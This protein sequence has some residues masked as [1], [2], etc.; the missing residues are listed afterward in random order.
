MSGAAGLDFGEDGRA[1]DCLLS[2]CGRI[3][4]GFLGFGFVLL[5]FEFGHESFGEAGAAGGIL[6]FGGWSE[7]AEFGVGDDF[8]DR[9]GVAGGGFGAGEVG[10]GDLES[11]EEEA[12][13]F[14][15]DLV[16]GDAAEDFADGGLDGDAVFRECDVEFLGDGVA[17]AEISD[18]AAGGVVVVAEFFVAEGR[19]AAAAAFGEDVTALVALLCV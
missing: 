17:L 10:A 8:F 19:A 18:G 3:F 2:G 1:G 12:G 15:V 5:A 16:A 4:G 7:G 9:L 14:G 13:A 6:V 11:V